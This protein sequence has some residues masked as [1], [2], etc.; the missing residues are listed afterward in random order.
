MYVFCAV[1]PAKILMSRQDVLWYYWYRRSLDECSRGG[2]RTNRCNAPVRPHSK[3]FSS[4][5]DAESG[6]CVLGGDWR[7]CQSVASRPDGA[8]LLVTMVGPELLVAGVRRRG[9]ARGAGQAFRSRVLR[10]GDPV[11][12]PAAGCV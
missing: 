9:N 8:L 12:L 2:W 4:D 10:A 5:F 3:R 6:G 11:V 7:A 1:F